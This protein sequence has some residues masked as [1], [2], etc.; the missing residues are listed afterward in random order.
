V[1]VLVVG[2]GGREHVLCWALSRSAAVFCAPGNPG[3]AE[4]GT[5]LTI[6][7]NDHPGI[8]DAVREHGIDLTVIGPEAPLAAGLVDDLAHAGFKAFG[9]TAEA[10][11]IEAS[12]AYAKEIIFAAGVP[13]AGSET[14]ADEQPRR[15]VRGRGQARRRGGVPHRRGAVDPGPHRRRAGDAAPGVSR[16]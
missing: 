8:V 4:L 11:Q 3:T 2:G 7:V 10:A 14:F 13:T 12:K 5:N 6:K 1:K 15:Q 16:P 9:P